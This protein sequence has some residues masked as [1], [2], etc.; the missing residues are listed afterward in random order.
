MDAYSEAHLFVAAI[1]IRHHQLKTPPSLEDVCEFLNVSVE[2]GG[3]VCRNLQRLGIIETME[4]PFSLR[5]S[6]TNHLEIEKIPRKPVEENS[7]A[8]ELE[9]FQSMKGDMNK[10]VATIQ[11]EM[12]KKKQNMFADIEAKFKKEMEKYKS[13]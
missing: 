5:L 4:D 2:A 12:K 1:R 10:K 8:R 3:A 7:L 11:E 9:K 6:V 13:D